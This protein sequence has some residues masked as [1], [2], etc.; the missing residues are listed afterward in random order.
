MA[1]TRRLFFEKNYPNPPLEYGAERGFFRFGLRR[2]ANRLVATQHRNCH[3]ARWQAIEDRVLVQVSGP[4]HEG[5]RWIAAMVAEASFRYPVAMTATPM[6]TVA[7]VCAALK[8][9]Q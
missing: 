1:I 7:L 6:L 5:D 8:T 2:R 4:G 9:R 3:D